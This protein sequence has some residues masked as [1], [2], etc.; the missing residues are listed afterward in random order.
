MR[1][2]HRWDM[3]IAPRDKSC[4]F[5]YHLCHK[6]QEALNLRRRGLCC[7]PV[8]RPPHHAIGIDLDYPFADNDP[9]EGLATLAER[10]EMLKG[11]IG[12][13][14]PDAIPHG[15]RPAVTSREKRPPNYIQLLPKHLQTHALLI[16]ATGCGK[17]NLIHHLIEQ[18][19]DLNQSFCILDLRGN[20]VKDALVLCAR[21]QVDPRRVRILDLRER[22]R[23]LGF[24]PLFG[25]G[26][27]YFRALNVLDAVE[28]A[29]ES[30]G[31]QIPETFRNVLIPLAEAKQ[32]MTQL[33][34]FFFDADFRRACLSESEEEPV[35]SF[36]KRF[37]ELTKERQA[38]LAMP[39]LNKVSIL[40]ATK[41]LR[42]ILGSDRPFDLSRH[43]DTKG[44]ITLVSL[45]YDEMHSAGQILGKMFLSS[46]CREV[47]ARIGIPEKRRNGVRLYVDEF[48]HFGTKDFE[49]ILAEGRKF[50]LR[51]V[52]A[53]Q[54]LAQLTPAMRSIILGNVG[55]KV[56]FRT[57][58]EDGVRLSKDLTGGADTYNFQGFR[59]GEAV[60]WRKPGFLRRFMVCPPLIEN[61]G[62]MTDEAKEY[63][64]R[65]YDTFADEPERQS[66]VS[67]PVE[68]PPESSQRKRKQS[69]GSLEDWLCE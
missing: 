38:G 28:D 17:T 15:D 21:K 58:F 5:A 50:R 40:F 62:E 46:L 43:L 60:L 10:L 22:E 41:T 69:T 26:P 1:S 24:D 54:T 61:S 56:V 55:A 33:D 25:A 67:T 64:E 18:D 44:S 3:Q 9:L 36:W 7:E 23:P 63:V 39:V 12:S 59:R 48:E 27:A 57:G 65:V 53:H 37:D 30:W 66:H 52:L 31:V 47:F 51:V 11:S 32:P 42:R 35:V 2:L 8:P 68:L 20:L 14:D 16:G 19:L 45:A 29:S 49:N 6:T 4:S 13:D 34:K